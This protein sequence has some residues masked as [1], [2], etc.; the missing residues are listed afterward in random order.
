MNYRLAVFIGLLGLWTALPFALGQADYSWKR[1]G[2]AAYDRQA[3]PE[4]ENAYR[5]ALERKASPEVKYN[6]GNSL[7][8]QQR[9][10]EAVTTYQEAL[11][12]TADP[13]LRA[14]TYFNLGNTYFRQQAYGE[15][16]GAFKEALKIRPDDE[17]ARQNLMMALRMLRQQQQQEQQQ[18]QQQKQQQ[19]QQDQQGAQPQGQPR[20]QPSAGGQQSSGEGSSSVSNPNDTRQ[21][22]VGE[23][24]S[25]AR[26]MGE[27]EARDIL[28]AI[29]R[30][31]QR[32]QE[33]LKKSKGSKPAP[34]KDW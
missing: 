20:D 17:M 18:E 29:E 16:A 32:V 8:Q 7:A 33:K 31:D 23:D 26:P 5:K 15:S 12:Q 24:D 25:N 10:D 3:F 30:E 6:L 34:V 13:Q 22:K 14:D 28:K 9:L 4:A 11:D 2:D 21:A 19:E 1:S 27:A